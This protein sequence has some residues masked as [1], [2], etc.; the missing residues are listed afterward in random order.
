MRRCRLATRRTHD[1]TPRFVKTL[2][3]K[4]VRGVISYNVLLFDL[5]GTL[6]DPKVGII[7]SIQYALEKLGLERA[8]EDTLLPF[9]GPPLHDSFQRFYGFSKGEADEAVHHYR[10]Y[11]KC[12]GLYENVAYPDIPDLL[13]DLQEHGKRL[14]VAT[15]KATAFATQ[16]LE[17]FKLTRYFEDVVGSTWDRS[18]SAKAD[19]IRYVLDNYKGRAVE[20]FLMIGDTEYDITGAHANGIASVGVLY[21]YGTKQALQGANPTYLV[22]TV[23]A[24]RKILLN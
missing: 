12:R 6:T 15:S 24:L 10:E 3:A 13:R 14:I 4:G 16:I 5:D 17:H 7:N 20:E 2:L 19:I 11:Y 23:G 1:G 18:R 21:G 22:P 9:I 8:S